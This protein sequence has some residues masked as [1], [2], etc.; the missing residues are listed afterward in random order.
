MVALPYPLELLEPWEHVPLWA[1][2]PP[3]ELPH[4]DVG[5][6]APLWDG[7]LEVGEGRVVLVGRAGVG[8][9]CV[10]NFGSVVRAPPFVGPQ[11][12]HRG[13]LIPGVGEH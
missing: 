11:Y 9:L 4:G 7:S 2:L 10:E 12:G 1:P 13:Q 8:W 3:L 6:N 5:E